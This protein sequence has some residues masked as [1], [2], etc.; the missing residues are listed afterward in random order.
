MAARPAARSDPKTKSQPSSSA[1]V[2]E[3]LLFALFFAGLMLLHAPL[4]RLPYF[5][6]EAGYYIP[7]ARDLYLSGTLIPYSTPSN[8]HPPL[9]LA[10]LAL[11]WRVAGY[12]PLVTRTAM[13]L[14]AS[15]SLLGFFRLA[16]FA[17]N[18]PVAW[19]TTA[20]VAL[21]PVF[22]TQSSLAHMDLAAAGFT[23]WGL[24]AY[25]EDPRWKP[26]LWFSLG[27]LAKE[28]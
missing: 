12:S 20:L 2:Q 17:A 18:L 13:L 28:T 21:Y 5:W 4:L 27:A 25:F 10:W 19:A 14:V 24:V 6:D 8:A 15:F 7:A 3:F 1:W 26:M 9:V 11:A 22:F 16:R 23:F